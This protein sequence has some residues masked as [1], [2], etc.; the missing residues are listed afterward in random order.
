M[1]SFSFSEVVA[2]LKTRPRI[3]SSMASYPQTKLKMTVPPPKNIP[4]GNLDVDRLRHEFLDRLSETIS[5]IKGG[6]HV[7]VESIY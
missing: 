3:E 7:A 5:S 6:R 1:P 2:N 4:L